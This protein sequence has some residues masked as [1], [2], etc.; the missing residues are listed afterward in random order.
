MADGVENMENILKIGYLNDKVDKLRGQYLE[1]YDIVLEKDE[2]L[3]VVNA[4]L[5]Y[6][7]AQN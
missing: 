2:T 3:N 6:I 7:S 1:G 5:Q 4:I